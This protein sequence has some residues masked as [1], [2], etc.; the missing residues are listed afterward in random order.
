MAWI[1]TTE[2]GNVALEQ[3]LSTELMT[4][5]EDIK[6]GQCCTFATGEVA[7]IDPAE[8]GPYCVA[9]EDIDN[10][11]EGLVAIAPTTLYVLAGAA[12]F[13]KGD[14]LMPSEVALEMGRFVVVST[15]V[16]NEIAAVALETVA[17]GLTAA[18]VRLG[19]F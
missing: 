5:A 19:Y 14:Y 11:D 7:D 18:K 16:F 6:K 3:G 4:A 17:N 9:L 13:N 15:P 2:A 12:G 8:L 10:G 1:E